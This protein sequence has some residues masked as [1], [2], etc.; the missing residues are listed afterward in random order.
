M[1][2]IYLKNG[3]LM[4]YGNPAGYLKDTKVTIDPMFKSKELEAWLRERNLNVDW[5]EGV[6]ERLAKGEQMNMSED[7]QIILKNVR[8]WQLKPDSDF[9]LRFRAYDETVNSYGEPRRCN[10]QTV[11]DGELETNDLEEIY[12]KFNINHPEGFTGHSLSIS[13]VIEIYD[14]G[15]SNIYYVDRIG[16]RS[17]AFDNPEPEQ[18]ITMKM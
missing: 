6:F 3:C 11:Y 2:N 12:S 13:D 7:A 16:F 5:K 9:D 10:Y 15:C 14:E 17:I 18:G 4:Y 1:N 8:I